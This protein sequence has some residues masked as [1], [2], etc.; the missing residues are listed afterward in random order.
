ME[1]SLNSL[2]ANTMQPNLD[3]TGAISNL[4]RIAQ[5]HRHDLEQVQEQWMD[6][7]AR[8]FYETELP[9]VEETIKRLIVYLQKNLEFADSA[10]RQAKDQRLE[11]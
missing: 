7:R 5:R 9:A 11:D 8:H 1:M 4:Q 6:S 2:L 10:L 3:I